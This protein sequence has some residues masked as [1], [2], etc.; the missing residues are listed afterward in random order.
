MEKGET[1]MIPRTLENVTLKDDVDA[2]PVELKQAEEEIMRL[3]QE[4]TQ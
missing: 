2:W 3:L 1:L 4:V